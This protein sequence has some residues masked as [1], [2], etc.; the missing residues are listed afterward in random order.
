MNSL[1]EIKFPR[2]YNYTNI[3]FR[4]GH[5]YGQLYYYDKAFDRVTVRTEKPLQRCGGT[6]YNLT[7]TEDPIIQKVDY[8]ISSSHMLIFSTRSQ[9]K[10]QFV[11]TRS[12]TTNQ[13]M[14]LV[15]KRL[16][17]VSSGKCWERFCNRYDISNADG[18]YA[19]S[20]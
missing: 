8:E 9:N 3:F 10:F 11:V 7:T 6:F 16:L 14:V 13:H 19:I 1:K 20:V 17:S 15:I 18:S 12:I 2:F 4:N 5:R